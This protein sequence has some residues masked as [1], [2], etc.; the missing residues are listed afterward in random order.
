MKIGIYPGTFDPITKGHSDIIVRSLKIVDKLIVAIAYDVIKTPLLSIEERISLIKQ[1]V[2]FIKNT[3]PK[4]KVIKI[5]GFKG[6]LVKFAH[7][8]NA[9]LIIRG[10]RAVSD[11]EYEFQLATANSKISDNIETVLL[12]ATENTHF[13]SSSI[14]KEIAR[15]GGEISSFVSPHVKEK[16]LGHYQKN[17]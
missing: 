9:S 5:E 14:V 10:L 7:Q 16:L 3:L 6:L 1:E 8:N 4:G 15:L 2:D 11:F 13:I 17:I 12:P